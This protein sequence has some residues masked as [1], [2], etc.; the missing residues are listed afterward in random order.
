MGQSSNQRV[1]KFCKQFYKYIKDIMVQIIDK[2]LQS[3][4]IEGI[5]NEKY[6]H[7]QNHNSR[8]SL[9]KKHIN[10]FSKLLKV[11]PPRDRLSKIES[12]FIQKGRK[13]LLK[14]KQN[15]FFLLYS[16][17]TF[18]TDDASLRCIILWRSF[19]DR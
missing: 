6:K 3:E 10:T 1:E 14:D 8:N 15:K 18:P 9:C 12:I 11:V 17:M 2:M 19:E 13:L 4:M 7:S 5:G 16:R